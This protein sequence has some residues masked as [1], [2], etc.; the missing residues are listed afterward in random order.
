VSPGIKGGVTGSFSGR[1][2]QAYIFQED[3]W[4]EGAMDAAHWAGEVIEG[5]VN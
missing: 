4:E 5:E 3:C 1:C 2:T